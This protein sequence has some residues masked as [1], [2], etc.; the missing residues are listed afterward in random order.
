MN[1]FRRALNALRSAAR[2]EA[3][4][5]QL[6]KA[7]SSVKRS[8]DTRELLRAAKRVIS[9][10]ATAADI[11]RYG[12]LSSF[13][14][15]NIIREVMRQLGPLGGVITAL[16]RPAGQPLTD[17][18]QREI[19]GAATLLTQFGYTIQPP[20]KPPKTQSAPAAPGGGKPPGG[21]ASRPIGPAPAPSDEDGLPVIVGRRE[22]RYSPDDPIMTG[23]MIPVVSS[24]VHSIGFG[25]NP[26][27]PSHGTLRVRFLDGKGKSRQ[28]AGSL[29]YYHG[30]HPD[31]FSAF[32]QAASKGK[33]VW[34]RLRVRG[35]VSGHRYSYDLAGTGD[36]GYIPRQAGLKRNRQGEWYMTR[37][38]QGR[39]SQLPEQQVR[40][41]R[42]VLDA[43]FDRRVGQM[44]L[45]AEPKRG[46]PNRGR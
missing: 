39:T 20:N 22:R 41:P 13:V 3:T 26:D 18:I 38:F 16:L 43:E 33:F 30:V 10:L 37:R 1:Q 9:P 7:L 35:T 11:E 6:S 45:R 40:G 29:Y 25:W 14:R 12:K 24:N 46:S 4:A 32:V 31:V 19:A 36:G 8:T 34:D 17:E 2:Q 44:Q 23:E 15:Q 21:V 5:G 42:G 28:G 27:N